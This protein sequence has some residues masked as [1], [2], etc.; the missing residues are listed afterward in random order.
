MRW[1]PSVGPVKSGA[2]VRRARRGSAL[3]VLLS[4]QSDEGHAA[5]V[6]Q[7]GLDV[8]VDAGVLQPLRAAVDRALELSQTEVGLPNSEVRFGRLLVAQRIGLLE[9]IERRAILALRQRL[10]ALLHRGGVFDVLALG[11][12]EGA[13]RDDDSQ[14]KPLATPGRARA[15]GSRA[16]RHH[17][18]RKKPA[19]LWWGGRG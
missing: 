12:D 4:A 13:S 17:A 15:A 5:Q 9:Q 18:S 16:C 8:F 1:P 10:H 3:R 11:A 19:A 14:Q 6:M 7:T 2:N